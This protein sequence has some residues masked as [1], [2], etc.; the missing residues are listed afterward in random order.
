MKTKFVSLMSSNFPTIMLIPETEE[1]IIILAMLAENKV[2]Y[3]AC[4][5][6]DPD[7]KG[8]I[9]EHRLGLFP[10]RMWVAKRSAGGRDI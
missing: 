9:A 4:A 1:E 5:S 3:E 8:T 6:Q 7:A 2:M 10:D